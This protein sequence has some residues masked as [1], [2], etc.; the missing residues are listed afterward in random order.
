MRENV[1]RVSRIMR[2]RPIPPVE[3][4][5]QWVEY[6]LQTNGA[7]HLRN[8]ADSFLW[9]NLYF[10]DVIFLILGAAVFSIGGLFL[11]SKCFYNICQRLCKSKVD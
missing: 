2:S 11:T 4:A 5:V 6:G 7:S 10:L 1:G 9:Y 8:K 3:L